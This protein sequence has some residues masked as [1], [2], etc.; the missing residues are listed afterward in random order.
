MKRAGLLLLLAVIVVP[1]RGQSVATPGPTTFTC[2]AVKAQSAHQTG[3]WQWTVSGPTGNITETGTLKSGPHFECIDSAVLVVEFTSTAGHTIFMAYFPDGTDISY[4]RQ[5]VERHGARW[6][7]PIQAK[8]RIAA[9]YRGAF[10]YHCRLE[11]PADPIP[12]ALRAD[13]VF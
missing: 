7:L 1:A 6:I 9:P 12:P 11:M 10:D 2:G 4:G 13:C 8:A 5:Q 3:R